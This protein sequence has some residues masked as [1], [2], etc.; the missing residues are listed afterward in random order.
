MFSLIFGKG[1]KAIDTQ[2]TKHTNTNKNKNKNN[3]NNK[4]KK[5]KKKKKTDARQKSYPPPPVTSDV[6]STLILAYSRSK[7]FDADSDGVAGALEVVGGPAARLRSRGLDSKMTLDRTLWRECVHG[8]TGRCYY[9]NLH[10]GKLRWD[11]P[12]SGALHVWYRNEEYYTFEGGVKVGSLQ[13]G[14][15]VFLDART[16][17]GCCSGVDVGWSPPPGGVR[18]EEEAMYREADDACCESDD[19]GDGGTEAEF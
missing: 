10:T 7:S 6:P 4:N 9:R 13:G 18:A 14:E 8:P 3:N 11:E 15:D 1:S 17:S 2:V 5:K 19:G 12:P 16:S